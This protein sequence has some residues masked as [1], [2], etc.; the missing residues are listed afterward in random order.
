MPDT[1]TPGPP[2]HCCQH[3]Q[4]LKPRLFSHI[5]LSRHKYTLSWDTAEADREL[6]HSTH[7]CP[8]VP[9]LFASS[10]EENLSLNLRALVG[11]GLILLFMNL[12]F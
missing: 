2:E 1:A 12:Y 9:P 7:N 10:T 8:S 4:A 11:L 3:R 6:A 5:E